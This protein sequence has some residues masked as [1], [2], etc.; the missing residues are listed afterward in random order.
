MLWHN[1]LSFCASATHS[2][3]LH[4]QTPYMY[5]QGPKKICKPPP[6]PKCLLEHEELFYLPMQNLAQAYH[7]CKKLD[8]AGPQNQRFINVDRCHFQL[9]F[10]GI[11]QFWIFLRPC[12]IWCR[13]SK[14]SK[15]GIQF[16][17]QIGKLLL[18]FAQAS[19]TLATLH[20]FISLVCITCCCKL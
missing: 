10:L 18:N 13:F 9:K 3:S 20:A 11:P 8:S 12:M 6:T 1:R 5:R 14:D 19:K 4:R 15:Y 16:L 7:L 17:Y 2:S